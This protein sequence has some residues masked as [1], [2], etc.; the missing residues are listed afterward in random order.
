MLRAL[1]FLLLVGASPVMGQVVSLPNFP[2]TGQY[3]YKI[4]F[5]RG[6]EEV[7]IFWYYG[8]EEKNRM[9]YESGVFNLKCCTLTTNMSFPVAGTY[10]LTIWYENDG[11][12]VFRKK[13]TVRRSWTL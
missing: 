9:V 2:D 3:E 5:P 4:V 12:K 13:Y 10:V 6:T 1:L 7:S 8:W 11:I